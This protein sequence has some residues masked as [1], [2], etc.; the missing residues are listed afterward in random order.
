MGRG[1]FS[2][3]GLG[4]VIRVSDRWGKK[5][6]SE[7]EQQPIRSLRAR[8]QLDGQEVSRSE[9]SIQ[10]PTRRSAASAA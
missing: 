2:A 1:Q 6:F 7:I 3:R 9:P 8:L 4:G 5:G 10:V